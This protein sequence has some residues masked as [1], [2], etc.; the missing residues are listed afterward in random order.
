MSF[1]RAGN[2]VKSSSSTKTSGSCEG[3][4]SLVTGAPKGI[5]K[6]IFEELLGLGSTVYACAWSELDKQNGL[7][8]WRGTGR[9]VHG[10]MS[11]LAFPP[12]KSAGS[13]SIVNVS[14]VAGVTAVKPG[15]IYAMCKAARSRWL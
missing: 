15:S 1:A 7:N 11:D 3:K 10:S 14:S 12:L 9:P 6:A 5:G 13:T 4:T 8:E 2:I